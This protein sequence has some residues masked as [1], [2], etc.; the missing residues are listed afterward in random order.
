LDLPNF[1]AKV[2]KSLKPMKNLRMLFFCAA[3]GYACGQSQSS[4]LQKTEKTTQK[5]EKARILGGCEG[6]EAVFEHQGN[7]TSD[8]Y[9]PDYQENSGKKVKISGVIY[10]NDGK[11]P[12]KDVILY[13]YHTDQKGLYSRKGNESGWGKRHGYIRGWLKTNAKGEYAIFTQHPASYPDTQFLAH[14]HATI[15]EPTQ[16]VYYIDEFVFV[17]DKFM[18]DEYRQN[19]E[20]RGGSGILQVSDNQ[21]LIESKR[22]IILGLNIPQYPKPPKPRSQNIKVDSPLKI[23]A[24]KSI[25]NWYGSKFAG[26]GKHEGLILIKSGT[27]QVADNQ[28]VGSEFTIDMNSI[29]VSDIPKTDPIPREKLRKHLLHQDF[30][31]VEKYPTAH[32]KIKSVEV[33]AN[34]FQ[35]I[36]GDMTIRGITQKIEFYAQFKELKADKVKGKAKLSFNRQEYGVAF[37]GKKLSNDLV[38]DTIILNIHFE[39]Q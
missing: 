5:I 14:I 38:D 19:E 13:V 8:L 30:F 29:E 15:H 3:L 12:A 1:A 7:L 35:L 36:K 24:Q 9:L 34:N 2:S 16:Q 21:G 25:I 18:N 39:T 20:K 26:L 28:L 22:D 37:R 11:T 4:H 27:L 17:D 32:F 6:C 10:Q 23:N 31:W 33:Q